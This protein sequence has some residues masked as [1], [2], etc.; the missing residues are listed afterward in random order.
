VDQ[1]TANTWTVVGVVVSIV[2]F[3]VT[4]FLLWRTKTAAEAAR[5]AVVET[6]GR[7]RASLAL[8]LL[9]QLSAIDRELDIVIQANDAEGAIRVVHLWRDTASKV[10]GLVR[11]GIADAAMEAPLLASLAQTQPTKTAIGES[12]K[13]VGQAT[14]IFR[15]S[16]GDVCL[17]VGALTST[18]STK[19]GGP[20]K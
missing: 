8:S 15:K 13:S 14:K 7:I 3:L 19:T 5:D 1:S 2:G 11:E 20:G 6:E 4:V 10:L 17:Q 12:S 9:S 16:V 18:L